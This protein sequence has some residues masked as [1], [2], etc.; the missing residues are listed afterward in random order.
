[1]NLRQSFCS[2]LAIAVMAGAHE[3]HNIAIH[4][5]V[6]NMDGKGVAGAKVTLLVA[7]LTGTT[8]D[9]GKYSLLRTGIDIARFSVPK[10]EMISINNGVLEIRLAKSSPVK[11]G[12]FDIK[13]NLQKKALLQTASA[14]VYRLNIWEH[15]FA[16]K[17]LIVKAMT[18]ECVTTLQYTPMSYS[19]HLVRSPVKNAGMGNGSLTK[20]ATAVIDDTLMTV[21]EGYDTSKVPVTSYD[22]EV[23]VTL[24]VV[25]KICGTSYFSDFPAGKT[26]REIGEKIAKQFNSTYSPA[27]MSTDVNDEYAAPFHYKAVCT[28]YGALDVAKLINDKSLLESLI[29][30]YTDN[31][32]AYD[33]KFSAIKKGSG[34]VDANILGMIP[35]EV[36]LLNG[37]EGALTAGT[38]IADHQITNKD[39]SNQKRYAADDMFM[40]TG[41]QV[42][43]YRATRDNKYIDFMA[44]RMVDYL[45]K[46]QDSTGCFPQKIGIDAKWGRGNGWFAAGMAEMLRVLDPSHKHYARIVEGFKKMMAGLLQYQIKDGQ[47]AGIWR[48][49]IERTDASNWP[50]T[51]GSAMFATAM[52]TGVKLCILDEETYGTAARSAWLALT[53]YVGQD[54]RVSQISDWCYYSSGDAYSYYVGRP[55]VTG[56]GHGQA[57]MLWAAAAIM[58]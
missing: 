19:K 32:A 41:L 34:S 53:N 24:K 30:K 55:K 22:Q 7:G 37:N 11:V 35:L 48:Q 9:S 56:D 28:W 58:R 2:F 49:V 44:E 12:I 43:A 26:P 27:T 14:G 51:S 17:M 38:A 25:N 47:G 20:V 52:I 45:D 46:M 50:E 8:D 6:T 57:P 4:G 23:N 39:A 40:V 3:K 36:N 42:Q 1:M 31:S 16:S 54:G 5:T 33:R 10:T 15:T 18:D 29:K 13:G 21:A